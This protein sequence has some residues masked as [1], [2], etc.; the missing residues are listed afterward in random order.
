MAPLPPRPLGPG[1]GRGRFGYFGQITPYK[2]IETVLRALAAV[3]PE[4]RGGITLEVN[5]AEMRHQPD[6]LRERID[7]L[8]RPLEAQ[9]S[10]QW[11]GAYEPDQMAE[12][13]AT[14]DWV[15]VPSVWWENS[16]MV[17]QEAFGHGRPVVC[18]DIGGMAEKVADEVDGVHVP[19]GSRSAWSAALRRLAAP[20]AAAGWDRLRAGITPPPTAAQQVERLLELAG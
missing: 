20:D 4:A 5:A 9:G 16:P 12:R 15:V 19:M 8:L 13:L 1:E 18:S 14:V 2:G 17:I 3:P 7:D 11:R 6:G 10:V